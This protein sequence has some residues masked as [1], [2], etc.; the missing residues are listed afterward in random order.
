[1]NEPLPPE[2][3]RTLAFCRCSSHWGVGSKWYFS[4][5]CLS[6]GALKSHIPSS[7]AADAIKPV[8]HTTTNNN[9]SFCDV[10]KAVNIAEHR[11]L[12]S[13]RQLVRFSFCTK[14]LWSAER[15]RTA[16][17]T[18]PR[19]QSDARARRTPKASR[20]RITVIK[21]FQLDYRHASE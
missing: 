20:N 16:F 4:L 12:E 10:E 8:A 3:K 21:E 2:L 11:T 7:A 15:P 14:C 19:S 5:S 13:A 17:H 1:M 6:G 9:R 18:K